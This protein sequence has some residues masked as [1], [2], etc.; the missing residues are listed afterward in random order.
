MSRTFHV[1]DL[2]S[3]TTPMLLSPRKLDG[4]RDL[5]QHLVGEHLDR[6][7]GDDKE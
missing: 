6:G 4:V 5:L 7:C 3:A 1:G 2:L